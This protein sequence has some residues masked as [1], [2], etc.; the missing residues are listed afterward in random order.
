MALR[1]IEDKIVLKRNKKEETTSF[2][3]VLAGSEDPSNEGTVVAVGPGITLSNGQLVT[4]DVKIGDKVVFS[5]FGGTDVSI[6]GEDFVIITI[7]DI[8][9]VIS[10][11]SN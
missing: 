5:K 6:D 11:E 10:D 9:V 4:P 8:L 3:L 2:G 7:R 1:P